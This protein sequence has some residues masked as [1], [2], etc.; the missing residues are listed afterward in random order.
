MLLKFNQ[1]VRLRIGDVIVQYRLINKDTPV[2][3]TFP[4]GSEWITELETDEVLW[5]F[6]FFKQQQINVISF[7]HTQ[8]DEYFRSVALQHFIEQLGASLAIFPEKIGYGISRGGFAVSLHANALG[9][10]RALLMMPLST[11][12]PLLA[13]WDPKVIKA[14]KTS[15]YSGDNNDASGCKTPLTIIYDPLL[16]PDRL[17]MERF[18]GE[19]Q[20]LKIS[21]VGHRIGRTLRDLGILKETVL[22]FVHGRL[23]LDNFPRRVRGRR[24]LSFYL[25]SLS[26]DPTGKLTLKRKQVIYYHKLLWKLKHI[27][28]EPRKVATRLKDSL[29]KRIN[30]SQKFLT[31]SRNFF[32]AKAFVMTNFFVFC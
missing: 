30:E 17:H 25:K 20:R 29:L 13:P 15:Q 22:D 6:D 27:E 2:V 19:V 10:D 12:S 5:G 18:S 8:Q 7:F 32:P 24:T 1:D 3:I 16:K 11:Y 9:L 4:P 28:D 31:C 23:D 21:G 26:S 14:D